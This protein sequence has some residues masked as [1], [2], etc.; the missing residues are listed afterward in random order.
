MAVDMDRGNFRVSA[1]HMALS[2]LNIRKHIQCTKIIR[3]ALFRH[4]CRYANEMA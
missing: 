3:V 2:D 1:S 4:R